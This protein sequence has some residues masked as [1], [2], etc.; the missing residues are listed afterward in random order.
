MTPP[1][2]A[3]ARARHLTETSYGGVVVRGDD[4]L[5]ITPAGRSV[6]ALP[7]GGAEREEAPER[8]EIGR[9]HV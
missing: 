8:T 2:G 1:E 3:A 4:V 9:A 6:V 5:V 7:K